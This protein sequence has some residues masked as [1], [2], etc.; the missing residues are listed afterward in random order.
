MKSKTLNGM[1]PIIAALSLCFASA[2]AAQEPA[3]KVTASFYAFDYVAGLEKVHV[4][5]GEQAFQEVTLSKANIVG[6]FEAV[7]MNGNLLIYGKPTEAEGKVISPVL[8]TAKLRKGIEQALVI[9]FRAPKDHKEPYGSLV[10]DHDIEDFPLGVYRMINVSPHPV[11]GAI[12]RSYIEAK[13]GGIANLKPEGNPGTVVPVK[14]EFFDQG[15]WNL[16]TE[17]RCAIRDDRRW[18]T[19]IYQDPV[20]GRLNIRSIPDRSHLRKPRKEQPLR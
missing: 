5:V 17:T 4:M 3:T 9:L 16:L 2:L 11:R 15:R 7:A 8:A 12:A 1:N 10:L 20:T 13:P 14:F 19:C 18:L 6:P